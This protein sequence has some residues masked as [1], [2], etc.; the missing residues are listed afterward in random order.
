MSREPGP[1]TRT[2]AHQHGW[3]RQHSAGL[4]ATRLYPG[5]GRL[6]ATPPEISN[7][8][9]AAAREQTS[10]EADAATGRS[11]ALAGSSP[12]RAPGRRCATRSC[13][14]SCGDGAFAFVWRESRTEQAA[15]QPRGCERQMPAPTRAPTCRATLQ[16]ASR[17]ICACWR[18]SRLTVCRIGNCCDNS[19]ARFRVGNLNGCWDFPEP[20]PPRTTRTTYARH[21]QARREVTPPTRT[22]HLAVLPASSLWTSCKR[23]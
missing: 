2:H 19:V 18:T 13:A 22:P 23:H 12:R 15:D 11:S 4:L 9:I 7:P 5:S 16:R 6:S 8:V 3:T 10:P 14:L 20:R 17:R 1:G 21:P